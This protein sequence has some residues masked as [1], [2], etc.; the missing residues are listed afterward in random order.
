M[1]RS[2]GVRPGPV[3]TVSPVK[4]LPVYCAL[5]PSITELRQWPKHLS[6]SVMGEC[7]AIN[8]ERAGRTHLKYLLVGYSVTY[9]SFG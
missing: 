1:V 2:E 4:A 8:H 3:G 5:F 6:K 7:F 9:V